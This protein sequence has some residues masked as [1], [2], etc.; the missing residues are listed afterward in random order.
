ML[1]YQRVSETKHDSIVIGEHSRKI[2]V[3]VLLVWTCLEYW[4]SSSIF[5]MMLPV[6][7]HIVHVH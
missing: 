5:G 7:E 3:L 6:D 1:D 4:L 2:Y